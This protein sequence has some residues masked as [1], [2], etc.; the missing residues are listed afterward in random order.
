MKTFEFAHTLSPIE[1]G[2]KN[3]YIY[4]LKGKVLKSLYLVVRWSLGTSDP[5]TEEL[6]MS[7]RSAK[8]DFSLESLLVDSTE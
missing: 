8:N 2:A 7:L 6:L 5:K 3:I 1:L 4:N